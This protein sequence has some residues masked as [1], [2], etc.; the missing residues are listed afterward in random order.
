MPPRPA[1]GAPFLDIAM[2]HLAVH[3]AVAAIDGQYQPYPKA[4]RGAAGSPVAA[5][6]RA[7]R[8]VLVNRFPAQMASLDTIYNNY[9]A[10]NSLAQNNPGVAVGQQAAADIIAMRASDG[11]YPSPA[12]PP[13]VGGTGIGMWRPTPPANA[14]MATPWLG[15][16]RPFGLTSPSQFL[17]D[18]PPALTSATYARDYNEVKELG[19]L[20]NSK[21]TA[22]QTD[23]AQFWAGNYLVMWN[24]ALR[25]IAGARALSI[26][27]SARLFALATMATADAAITAWNSKNH[28]PLWR[29]ITAIQN[30][31]DDG[32]PQTAGD[33]AWQPLITT[34]PYPDYTSGANNVTGA[35]T[36]I[37]RLFFGRDDHTFSVT[38]TVADAMQKTRT[39]HKF[40]DAARDVVDARIYDGIHFRF[41]DTA[42]RRQG[43]RVAKWTFKH[44]LRPVH[45]ND[46]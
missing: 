37:L 39:Y 36:R 11:S 46:D 14:A 8:D 4:I 21:R 9:L 10:A 18:P 30:G 31:D 1:G 27:R 5:A 24:E 22:Q 17:A 23:L 33:R 40:S 41:A 19:S 15:D 35:V 44:F 43:Q 26:G 6:A 16:V 25:N 32:N 28:Y 20:A 34:P 45:G 7:A 38:T 3:N 12:P 42:A 13:F 2:V 29:P